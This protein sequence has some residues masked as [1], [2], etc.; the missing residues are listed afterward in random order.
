LESGMGQWKSDYQKSG[1][2]LLNLID[3]DNFL[4][5][6][7]EINEIE[8]SNVVQNLEKLARRNFSGTKGI[9]NDLISIIQK[10][11]HGKKP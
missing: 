7:K 2:T 3:S 11:I 5:F 9:I 4:D 8:K 10:E 1:I 6:F